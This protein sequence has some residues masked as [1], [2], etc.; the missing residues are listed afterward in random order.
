M[1]VHNNLS[2]LFTN[3]GCNSNQHAG[4]YFRSD[5]RSRQKMRYRRLLF[6][7]DIARSFRL[8]GRGSGTCTP[9]P[10]FRST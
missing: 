6:E 5:K 7:F 8:W 10:G 2:P 4:S 9:P 1:C 3:F